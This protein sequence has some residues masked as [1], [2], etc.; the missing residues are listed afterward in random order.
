MQHEDITPQVARQFAL[1]EEMRSLGAARYMKAMEKEDEATLP[2]G[3]LLVKTSL[4]RL[5]PAIREWVESTRSGQ[6]RRH[7]SIA[8]LIDPFEPEEVALLALRRVVSGISGKGSLTQTAMAISD[9]L[10]DELEYR[11]FAAGNPA[12]AKWNAEDIRKKP[13][14]SVK[15]TVTMMRKRRAGIEDLQWTPE[16]RLRLGMVLIEMVEEHCG[17]IERVT[18]AEGKTASGVLKTKVYITGTDTIKEWLTKQHQHCQ[19][20]APVWLPMVVPP[21]PWTGPLAGGYL[22]ARLK[23]VKTKNK[24]Y[25]EEL[26]HIDLSNVYGAMNALQETRWRINRKVYEVMKHVWENLKGDRAKLPS[27]TGRPMPNKP[28]DIDTNEEA[29]KDYR[30]KAREVV[31]FNLG[32]TSRIA[33][34]VQ[35][36][37]VAERFLEEEAIYFPHVMDWRGRAYPVPSF[38]SPQSDDIGRGLLEFA[39]GKPLGEDG[40]AWLAVHV[41]NTWGF[42]KA[43]F[44]DRI[45]WVQDNEEDILAYARDPYLFTGWMDADS[46]WCFLAA[47][48]EWAGYAE[49]GEDHIS[50]IQVQMDGSC[51]G[52]QNFSAMLRDPV[53]GAAVNLVPSD[54][55]SD[56]YAAVAQVASKW[57]EVD[58]KEGKPE[59]LALLGKVNRKLTKS[60]T[61]TKPYGVSAYGMRDQVLEALKKGVKEGWLTF[62]EELLAD[63]L[64]LVNLA[65]Y[66]GTLNYKAIDQVVVAAKEAM[67][68]LQKTARVVASNGLPITWVSPIGLPVIQDYRKTIGKRV[69]FGA[70]GLQKFTLTYEGDELDK[71]KQSNGISPNFVHSCDAS[72]MMFTILD[73]KENGIRHF[74]FIHD[75]FGCHASDMPIMTTVLRSAFVKMYS[76]DVLGEFREAIIEQLQGTD[77]AKEVPPLPP[78]GT[79][80]LEAVNQSEYFFA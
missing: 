33:A 35:K 24:P 45:Q 42:D 34:T 53:G 9:S 4:G 56:I 26:K 7:A 29:R 72:H 1:E 48:F 66:L 79:L 38:V 75:S 57:I 12:Y 2:P 43:P 31:E 59:A 18:M 63:R 36:L 67:D 60:N 37:W 70:G 71:R 6:A 3:Q 17:I 68:W 8:N 69:N 62:P 16:E 74:S 76:R 49:N 65:N 13:S 10:K 52:L 46:P 28:L 39:D 41:S 50:H 22:T 11:A 47:C 64:G 27:L 77:L 23:L 54:K 25:L 55:P 15:R 14:E 73:C 21:T 40:V 32:Q 5:A 51:N 20:M 61:M 58:A 78:M 80:D 30:A 44:E 19:L